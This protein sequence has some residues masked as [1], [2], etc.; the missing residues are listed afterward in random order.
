M[1]NA[2]PGKQR[3][4]HQRAFHQKQRL[5]AQVGRH[6]HGGIAQAM[7]HQR[8]PVAQALGARKFK[9]GRHHHLQHRSAGHTRQPGGQ[10]QPQR[11]RGQ[12]QAGLALVTARRQKAPL[13]RH[14]QDEQH[15]QQKRRQRAQHH[16]HQPAGLV[17]PALGAQPGP[18]AQRHTHGKGNG[19]RGGRQAQRGAQVVRDLVPHRS[20][21]HQ[22]LPQ[23][24][25]GH[26]APPVQQRQPAGA[27]QP[28]LCAHRVGGSVA[29]QVIAIAARRHAH[30]QVARQGAHHQKAQRADQQ[31]HGQHLHQPAAEQGGPGF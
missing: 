3:L 26:V 4:H 1:A 11:E 5:H 28:Q 24:E 15:R 17:H 23:V 29:H 6:R 2:G 7:A 13:H 21:R 18:H 9:K 19:Q 20:L 30:G 27:V 8:L 16:G 22:R 31:G 12:H 10:A 25:R 14:Q